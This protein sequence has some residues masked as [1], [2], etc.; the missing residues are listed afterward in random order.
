M[1]ELTDAACLVQSDT[2]ICTE[3]SG[4]AVALDIKRGVCYGL[5]QVGTRIWQLVETPRTISGVVDILIDEYDVERGVCS[6]Q[7][8]SLFADL[9]QAGLIEETVPPAGSSSSPS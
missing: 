1:A 5:N 2:A 3:I 9:L 8:R 4:E 7:T 6:Q